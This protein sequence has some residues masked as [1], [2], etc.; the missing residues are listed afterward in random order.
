MGGK[1]RKGEERGHGR[2]EERRREGK[3]GREGMAPTFWVKF[4]PLYFSFRY[5]SAY[6]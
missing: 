2:T 6:K 5:N 3:G 4:T 1:D